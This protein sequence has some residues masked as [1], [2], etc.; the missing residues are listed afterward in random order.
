MTQVDIAGAAVESDD[1]HTAIADTLMPHLKKDGYAL[2]V[3][4][5][6]R[7]QLA[8]LALNL[9]NN[10]LATRVAVCWPDPDEVAAMVAAIGKS[11]SVVLVVR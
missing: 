9:G 2:L 8:E 10:R 6:D 5:H 4:A 11:F 7:V 3:D 1:L